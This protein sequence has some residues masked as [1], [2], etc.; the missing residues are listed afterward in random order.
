M[1]QHP[2]TEVT[3]DNAIEVLDPGVAEALNPLR[4]ADRVMLVYGEELGRMGLGF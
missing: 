2:T 4:H 1:P 3:P